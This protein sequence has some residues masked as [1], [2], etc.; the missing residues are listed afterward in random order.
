MAA[1]LEVFTERGLD[2]PLEEV[3]R[4]AGVSTGTVYNRFGSREALIDAVVPDL[5]GAK[6]ADAIEDARRALDPWERF[7]AYVEAISELMSTD[8]ALSDVVT[9]RHDDSPRLREVCAESFGHAHLL[10]RNAQ[11]AG[12][13]RG[14]FR[15]EDL[16]L[17]FGSVA[18]LA[19][20]SP[21]T[22]RRLLC[23]LLDGLRAEAA[24]R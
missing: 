11:R 4:R 21:G 2:C 1:A 13:L 23:F 8:S 19:R 5:A 14:D 15:P 3:A 6:L 10:L 24:G 12:S 20:T 16:S 18:A 17:L 7:R 9:R 22:W